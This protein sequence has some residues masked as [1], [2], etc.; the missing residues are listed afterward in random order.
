MKTH[1]PDNERIKRSYFAYMDEAQGF[2]EATLDSIAKAI[3]RGDES[4]AS[5]LLVACFLTSRKPIKLFAR[6]AFVFPISRAIKANST[7]KLQS[8]N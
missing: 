6:A 7:P 3:M 1:N 2:S 4:P 5:L 8:I